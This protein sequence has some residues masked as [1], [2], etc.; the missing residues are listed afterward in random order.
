MKL[1]I[2]TLAV[3]AVLAGMP[4]R[5]SAHDIYDDSQSHPLRIIAYAVNP[6]GA[7][8]EWIVMRPMHFLVSDP[9]LEPLFGHTPHE[10]P[11]STYKSYD[12]YDAEPY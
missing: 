6:I 1:L 4:V 3:A 11:F 2:G 7:A 10:D 5:A 12:G 9:Q 8:L